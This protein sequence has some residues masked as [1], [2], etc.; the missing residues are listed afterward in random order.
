MNEEHCK[1][2]PLKEEI[3]KLRAEI[4]ELK[5]PAKHSGNS[6]LPPS[7]DQNNKHY[8]PRE[9]TGRKPGGQ[10]GHKGH[11]KVLYDNPDEIIE[12]YPPKCPHCGNYHFRPAENILEQRQVVDIPEI[13]PHVT[14]YRKKAGICTNCGKRV[15]GEFPEN[16]AP[17][18]QMGER[19]KALIG[20]LNVHAHMS[21]DKIGQFF[22]DI[23]DFD[24]S[25]G[26]VNN[27]INELAQDLKPKYNNILEDLKKSDVL[28][29]DETT[30]RINGKKSYLWIFQNFA[31]TFF[32]TGKRSFKTIE[33]LI[34]EAYEGS[35]ISDRYGAQ[36]KVE[37]FH[38][39][40]LAH[41]TR[42]CKY[43]VEAEKSEWA[44]KLKDLFKRAMD[45]KKE[46]GE[47]FDPLNI[48]VFRSTKGFKEELAELFQTPPPKE[49]EKKLYKGL[50][51]RQH[52]LLHFLER[53]EVP[54]TNNDSERGLRNCVVH[55]KVTGGFRSDA[56]AKAHDII[57][58]VIETAKKQGQ[59]ILHALSPS[60][61]ILLTA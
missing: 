45:F 49:L 4:E 40:C 35:W 27:K 2:C 59:N 11:T 52:Q 56:G 17:N 37:S 16:V 12:L 57:A 33:E 3:A 9:R 29:S 6:S 38:Q 10:P 20:Y 1:N 14:E 26:T 39:L 31:Y 41:L 53:K 19:A 5:K 30:A 8:P 28:G 22:M 47:K 51:G 13:K 15:V 36:L 34:G 58:S 23:M 25:K 42:E 7:S 46:K 43:L 54:P 21:N 32:T 60:P 24:I 48:E 55:R 18:L 61:Q 50:L 44:G